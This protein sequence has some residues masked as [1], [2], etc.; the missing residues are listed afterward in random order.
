M[1]EEL[2]NISENEGIL[3]CL[4]DNKIISE[5]IRRIET[6]YVSCPVCKLLIEPLNE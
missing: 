3:Q 4:I 2:F 5:V 1:Y 6:G